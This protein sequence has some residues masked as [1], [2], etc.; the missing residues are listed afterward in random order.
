MYTGKET[1]QGKDGCELP[2]CPLRTP[3]A[4]EQYSILNEPLPAGSNPANSRL[5]QS[6]LFDAGY[7]LR[8]IIVWDKRNLVNG[9]GSFG[10]PG[11]Y[12]TLTIAFEYILD[13]WK[14]A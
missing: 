8:N 11:N 10:W 12:I 1:Q 3:M 7:E 14:P 5:L 13:F 6:S 9:V 2:A 4:N